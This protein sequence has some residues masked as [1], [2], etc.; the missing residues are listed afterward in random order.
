ML[1]YL[2]QITLNLTLTYIIY[3]W[4][5]E[6][7]KTHRFNRFYLLTAVILS[8]LLPSIS[9]NSNTSL[10]ELQSSITEISEIIIN[11]NEIQKTET[12]FNW[13]G[14]IYLIYFI[15]FGVS[16]YKFTNSI[17]RLLNLKKLG[18]QVKKDQQHFVLLT[19]V[20]TPFTFASTIYLPEFTPIDMS[21]DIIQH[22]IAHVK[23]KHS[24]DILL[25]E[26]LHCFFWF[27]PIFFFFKK[28]IALNHEFLADDE[29]TSNRT[30]SA[31]YLKL[32]LNQTYDNNELPLSSSFNFNLTKK[33]FI[34]ITR[35]NNPLKNALSITLAC[36]AITLTGI[37][38]TQAQEKKTKN[39]QTK[40]AIQVDE[41]AEP[42]GGMPKFQQDFISKIHTNLIQKDDNEKKSQIILQFNVDI[43]GSIVD[44][45]IL[46]SNIGEKAS[47][48]ILEVLKNAEKWKPA[49]IAGKAVKSQF[50]LPIIIEI[51]NT[52]PTSK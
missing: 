14:L 17:I 48:E 25:I 10:P 22:E 41:N 6:N 9:I 32:L 52:Q 28:S 33:R 26:L 15:G 7:L 21:D 3:K 2:I 8:L 44:A 49:K 43:D 4:T 42:I 30:N 23:Q 5:L 34:M 12:I 20:K 50:T 38:S 1:V 13:A 36:A 37:T 40:S 51:P 11:P 39:E 16:I 24:L 35:K 19:S 18:R 27:H 46:R 29:V 45:Q 31:E 47:K